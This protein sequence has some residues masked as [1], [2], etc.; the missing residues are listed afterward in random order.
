MVKPNVY[1]KIQNSDYQF[2]ENFLPKI[3]EIVPVEVE[4]GWV[5]GSAILSE[6]P[7]S[8]DRLSILQQLGCV[9]RNVFVQHFSSLVLKFIIPYHQLA[10]LTNLGAGKRPGP[11]GKRKSSGKQK[12]CFLP[13]QKILFLAGVIAL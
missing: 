1:R 11:L 12:S 3:K 6:H 7:Q 13:H 9:K 4:I 2:Y 5:I 8:L 10:A